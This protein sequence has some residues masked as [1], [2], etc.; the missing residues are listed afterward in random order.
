M[1]V[2]DINW[3]IRVKRGR[4]TPEESWSSP[5]D[6]YSWCNRDLSS[7][8]RVLTPPRGA[9]AAHV[10]DGVHGDDGADADA[11]SFVIR[12]IWHFRS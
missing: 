6:G 12:R 7:V 3:R 9:A 10:A 11:L 5:L 4:T 1:V 2:R 8:T